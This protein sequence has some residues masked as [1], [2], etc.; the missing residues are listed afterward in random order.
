[1]PS[2]APQPPTLYDISSSVTFSVSWIPPDSGARIM[3]YHLYRALNDSVNGFS[4]IATVNGT[5]Y[6]DA[7]APSVFPDV[8]YYMV[9]AYNEVGESVDSNIKM[10]KH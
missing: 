1:M 7:D 2:S 10:A 5:S 3:G 6:S 4:L 9:R 8:Y